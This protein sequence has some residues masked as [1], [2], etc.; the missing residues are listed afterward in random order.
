VMLPTTIGAIDYLIA[1][2]LLE[3]SRKDDILA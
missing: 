2:N 1:Q 3:S